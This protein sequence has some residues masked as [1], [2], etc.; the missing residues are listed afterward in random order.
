MQNQIKKSRGRQNTRRDRYDAS[1]D[2]T[3]GNKK[4]VSA[5]DSRSKSMQKSCQL[6]SKV[7]SIPAS[8]DKAHPESTDVRS[9]SKNEQTRGYRLGFNLEVSGQPFPESGR[10]LVMQLRKAN[11]HN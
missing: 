11:L 6:E 7:Q 9:G 2:K 3:D 10:Q 1:S 4:S 5:S 8:V